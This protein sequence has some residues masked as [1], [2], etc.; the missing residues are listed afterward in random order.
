MKIFAVESS[1]KSA[2][3]A[4][5][6]GENL[7]GEFYIRTQLTHS[8]T[9]MPMADALLQS[10]RIPLEQVDAFAVST[11]PGSFTGIRIG[12]AAIKGL[13]MAQEKP[14]VSISTLEA[15]GENYRGENALV[16]AVMDARC[17]QVYNA[18]FDCE[19]GE[20]VRLCPDRALSM[21]ALFQELQAK[22]ECRK[23]ELIFVGDGARLCWETFQGR[24]PARIAPEPLRYQRAA[25][26]AFAALR[27]AER[28]QLM[29]AA[30]LAPVY[31]RLPQATREL[32]KRKGEEGQ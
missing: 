16:C 12:V 24:F 2:S 9:L 3:A 32:N 11:G 10:A 27:K 29:T 4:L 1:A 23:K 30:E 8:E 20:A 26:V 13:A 15:I 28:G 21:E 14:C 22:E 6:D 19:N 17:G 31:L 25:N 7:L 5:I 18:L